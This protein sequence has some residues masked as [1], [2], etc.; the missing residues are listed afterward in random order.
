MLSRNFRL[1]MEMVAS[2]GTSERRMFCSY[3]KSQGVDWLYSDLCRIHVASTD[4]DHK[5]CQILLPKPVDMN[6]DSECFLY[7]PMISIIKVVLFV[8]FVAMNRFVDIARQLLPE[9]LTCASK[10]VWVCPTNLLSREYPPDIDRDCRE[11]DAYNKQN[12]GI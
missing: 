3:C 9:N 2:E 8:D 7:F 5:V 12:P 10:M 11:R 1:C 6:M 4:L